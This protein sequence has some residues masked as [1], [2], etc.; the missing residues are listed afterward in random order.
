MKVCR[1]TFADESDDSTWR[2][3]HPTG[4]VHVTVK[5]RGCGAVIV[6]DIRGYG[7]LHA[8]SFWRETVVPHLIE[9]PTTVLTT[10]LLAIQN[11]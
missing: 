3:K 5:C 8:D 11:Q 6:S 4:P 1:S 7:W 9:C 10:F 2:E